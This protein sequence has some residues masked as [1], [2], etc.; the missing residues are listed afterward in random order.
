MAEAKEKAKDKTE[1]QKDDKADKKAALA[2]ARA[3]RREKRKKA[4]AS[5]KR[6]RQREWNTPMTGDGA[7]IFKVKILITVGFLAY[8]GF[9][10]IFFTV[11]MEP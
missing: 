1:E 4:R 5:A 9:V 11:F 2:A 8:A 6:R 3:L 10:A 7:Y